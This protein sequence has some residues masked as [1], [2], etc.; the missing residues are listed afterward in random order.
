[1]HGY[2]NGHYPGWGWGGFGYGYGAGLATGL[3]AWGLGS[4]LYSGWGYMPYYNPYY[5]DFAAAG[6][7]QPVYDYSQPIDTT[8]APLDSSVVDP[9]VATFDQARQAFKSTTPGR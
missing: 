8:S 9:A 6:V 2:W 5:S 1:V 4:A 3:L 7:A